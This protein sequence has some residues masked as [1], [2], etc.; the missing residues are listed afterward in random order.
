VLGSRS[1][2]HG[3][4]MVGWDDEG[5]VPEAFPLVKEGML[6]DFATSRATASALGQWYAKAGRPVLSHGCTVADT[7]A[8]MPLIQAPD[9]V[10]QP[11]SHEC[12][13]EQLVSSV[14][15]GVAVVRG[16]CTMDSQQGS[17]QG[18]G[19]IYEI[20]NGKLGRCLGPGAAF[21]FRSR[22]LWKNV[23]ALG[24]PSSAVMRGFTS[25]KGEP[26][27]QVPHG[28]LAVPMHVQ[29]VAVIDVLRG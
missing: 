10:L 22:E 4:A 28:V 20:V 7:A 26:T 13:F 29:N 25:E 17:G 6:V 3:P 12:S 11:S 23:V 15:Q 19:T 16:D 1:V 21:L 18:S 9:L 14:S 8:D 24:G 27:Q 5:V 2:P